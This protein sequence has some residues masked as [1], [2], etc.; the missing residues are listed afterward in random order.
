MESVDLNL[1]PALD[2]LLAEGS[3]TGAARRLGLSASAMSRTLARLRA[4]T[5]D[6]LLVRAGR[7]LV[8][9]PRAIELRERVH[10]LSRE[11]QA[12]LRPVT[13]VLDPATLDCGFTLRANEAFVERF[14]V[15]LYRAVSDVAPRVRLQFVHKPD[16]DAAPLRD[17]R[18]DLE[19][20][21]VGTTAPEVR[22]RLLFRDRYVGAV[23]AGHPLLASRSVTVKRLAA[24]GHVAA[25]PGG[26]ASGP[27][28][29]A[30]ATL[31]LH[32]DVR[33]V[34][35]GFI[36]ALAVAR[37]TDLVAVVPRSCLG[38]ES[39]TRR[40]GPAALVAFELPLKLS[41]LMVSAIW[42][43]RLDA[44]PAHRW[45]RGVVLGVCR[46]ICPEG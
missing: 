9:S 6:P 11:A 39:P 19:I 25:A 15:P 16:K 28:D 38:R 37:A 21:V 27:V 44:D 41:P 42:H 30:L 43:P 17:G 3:V 10:A 33:V 22:S 14:A 35:P 26:A 36:D 8:P 46:A 5:G 40:S 45:L 34:V 12:V 13:D 7:G 23:R 1:L 2:A 24:C 20:G 18:I 32:R 29:E 4:A 31:G